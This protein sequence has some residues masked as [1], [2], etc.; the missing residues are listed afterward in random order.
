VRGKGPLPVKQAVDC[1]LQAARGLEYAH[2][3]GV[4]HRDIKPQNI[5]LDTKG[6]V[7]ILDMGLA[8]LDEPMD[9]HD[10]GL[11][12]SGTVMG[13]LDYM[14]PEQAMDTKSADARADIYS[15]GCTLHYLVT[16]QTPY[17]GDSLAAKIFAHR[18]EPVPSLRAARSEV[19]E[20]LDQLFRQM[21]GKTP[22]D[23]QQSMTDLI[24]A[25]EALIARGDLD[26]EQPGPDD[27]P[28]YEL[29]EL[30]QAA[31]DAA[32]L[33]GLDELAVDKPVE[34]TERLLAPSV[35][36]RRRVPSA[37]WPRTYTVRVVLM[38]LA[39]VC[40]IAMLGI[41]V[42]S[43]R[44]K[45]GT[46]VVEVDQPG[47]TVEVRDAEGK[48]LVTE[49]SGGEPLVLTVP[50]GQ[51]R[52]QV[53]KAGFKV[54]GESIE[55]VTRGKAT[56]WARLEKTPATNEPQPPSPSAPA[57]RTE[58]QL[59]AGAPKP[60][61]A[62]FDAAQ[63]KQHQEAWAKYLNVP[64]EMK[65]SVGM[66]FVLIP[67]GEFMMGSSGNEADCHPHPVRLTRAFYLG[68]HEVAQ[69]R[70]ESVAGG[71]NSFFKG[72]SHPAEQ[73]SWDR[74]GEFAQKLTAHPRID[75]TQVG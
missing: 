17:R 67:P 36:D 47:A 62:P 54:Y 45:D 44:T 53:E 75:E 59:P 56:V 60:A 4:I 73:V 8:R 28:A 21:L 57:A 12:H 15:L 3:Q 30:P 65:N 49:A 42:A 68:V 23:R 25:I 40:G 22:T 11:T 26:G 16:G 34:L 63:A 14:A 39:A 2:G 43:L 13:T 51:H 9:T 64:L 18:M 69:E 52:V 38:A 20:T 10:E 46:L 24:A 35:R 66:T 29:P 37:R 1:I 32:D 55:L 74:A 61:I 70:F 50:P 27:P 7:K 31:E 58:W 19:P 5:L 6:T 72:A 33:F 41:V 48:I 71:E